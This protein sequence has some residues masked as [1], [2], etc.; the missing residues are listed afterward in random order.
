MD[1]LVARLSPILHLT[2][3][4][5]AVAAVGNIWFVILWTRSSPTEAGSAPLPLETTQL[6]LLLVAGAVMAIALFSFAMVLNDAMDHRRDRALHPERPIPSGRVTIE[7]AAV[8]ISLSLVVSIL[9]A[10]TM[11][12]AAVVMTAAVAAAIVAYNGALKSVPSVGLVLVGVIYAGH[13]LTPN[14]RLA[15]IYP[16]I[17]AMSHALFVGLLTHRLAERRPKLSPPVL[18]LAALGWAFW[19]G[20]LLWIGYRRT[21]AWWPDEVPI[22]V[23]LPLL[24]LFVLFVFV[25]WWKVRGTS[26]RL[27]A[28]HKVQR[29]GSLW[30]TLYATAWLAG[31]GLW[32]A[33]LVLV[34]LSLAGFLG[35][36]FLRELYS[37]VEHPV[38]FRRD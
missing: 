15:F 9:A 34:G 19:T 2:R 30:L 28:A 35:M 18:G 16:V 8:L 11:G 7:T 6:A 4:T 38:G 32:S 21:G 14:P 22:V 24:G 1:S 33:A 3:I 23:L 36:T 31:A 12:L 25:A 10:A 26:S 37:L 17:W 13:M 29:Y 5:N 20:L 27:R